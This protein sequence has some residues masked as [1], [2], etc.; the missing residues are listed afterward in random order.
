MVKIFR[1]KLLVLG[2][3]LLAIGC[4]D[5]SSETSM[6]E[7]LG[8][9]GYETVEEWAEAMSESLRNPYA[10]EVAVLSVK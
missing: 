6:K 3:I 5:N 2:I 9:L 10:E 1:V 7:L 8:M 4:T